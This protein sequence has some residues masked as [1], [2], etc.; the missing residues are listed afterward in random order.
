VRASWVV[1]LSVDVMVMI[2]C[3]LCSKELVQD[4]R[5][6]DGVLQATWY[7]KNC[8]ATTDFS[9]VVSVHRPDSSYTDDSNIVFVARGKQAIKLKWASPHQL[10][11]E[12]ASCE[13]AT[14]FRE[15]TKIGNI[16]VSF[17]GS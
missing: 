6:P 11:V 17:P 10:S 4:S 13:R 2:G 16:D 7:T 12:C 9:T 15:V 14:I 3:G 8:G 1:L 5:S